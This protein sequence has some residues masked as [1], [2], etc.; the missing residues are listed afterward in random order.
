MDKSQIILTKQY[1]TLFFLLKRKTSSKLCPG[2]KRN[3]ATTTTFVQDWNHRFGSADHICML[4]VTTRSRQWWDVVNSTLLSSQLRAVR[5][6]CREFGGIVWTRP[7]SPSSHS[8]KWSL[9]ITLCMQLT[10]CI[11]SS[12]INHELSRLRKRMDESNSR[13][14]TNNHRYRPIFILLSPE[15]TAAF[16]IWTAKLTTNENYKP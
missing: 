4:S 10:Q 7:T 9:Q 1:S 6:S 11:L 8:S 2:T 15:Q 3:T 14:E 12:V 16:L 13:V 5:R